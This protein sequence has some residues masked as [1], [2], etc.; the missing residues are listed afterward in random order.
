MDI[1][2]NKKSIYFFQKKL[3]QGIVENYYDSYYAGNASAAQIDSNGQTSV[4]LAVLNRLLENFAPTLN[5][6]VSTFETQMANNPMTSANEI[7]SQI[8]DTFPRQANSY[9]QIMETLCQVASVDPNSVIKYICTMFDEIMTTGITAGFTNLRGM[10]TLLKQENVYHKQL[11]VNLMHFFV[12]DLACV[13]ISKHGLTESCEQLIDCGF[14]LCNKNTPLPWLHN[15]IIQQW[16]VLFS[17][18]SRVYASRII[19]L[20]KKQIKI[21]QTREYTFQMISY[22]QL[23]LS[24]AE[25]QEFLTF[26]VS[27]IKKFYKDRNLTVRTLISISKLVSTMPKTPHLIELF[28]VIWNLRQDSK[29]KDGTFDLLASLFIRLD[30]QEKK[31]ESFFKKRVYAHTH[32][33]EKV[34]RSLR[35]FQRLMYGPQVDL[36]WLMWNWGIEAPTPQICFIKWNSQ[37]NVQQRESNSFSNLFMIHFFA[38]S[39]FSTAPEAFSHTLVHLASIDFDYFMGEIFPKFLALGFNDPRF[40]VL[41]M[42]V[43]LINSPFF[44]ENALSRVSQEKIAIMNSSMVPKITEALKVVKPD[45]C[46]D[47]VPFPTLDIEMKTRMEE[48]DAK[49]EEKLHAWKIFN[50]GASRANYNF[51]DENANPYTTPVQLVKTLRFILTPNDF[52]TSK[53]INMCVRLSAHKDRGIALAAL[54]I[55]NNI[56]ILP[57]LQLKFVQQL[58]ATSM[59][60]TT[61]ET[62]FL[63][64]SLLLTVLNSGGNNFKMNVYHDI[65]L[66]GYIGFVSIHPS[67]R[68]LA[69]KL[70]IAVNECLKGRGSIAFIRQNIPMMESVV[71]QRIIA[72]QFTDSP[73]VAPPSPGVIN[74]ESA[75]L[76]HIYDV[77]LSFISEI[78]NIL[79]ATNYTPILERFH[80]N[81]QPSKFLQ[82]NGETNSSSVSIG[83]L[84]LYTSTH[85]DVKTILSSPAPYMCVQYEPY[86]QVTDRREEAC[87]H[88]KDMLNSN[89]W[90]D[91]VAFS[92]MNSI[93]ISL[94]P[95]VLRLLSGVKVEQI[96]DAIHTIAIIFRSP[97]LASSYLNELLPQLF[98][99]LAIIQS[100]FIALKVNSPRAMEWDK[101]SED[102]VAKHKSIIIDYCIILTIALT[103]PSNQ[104]PDSVW[105]LPSREIVFRFLTNWSTTTSEQLTGVREYAASAL[106][107]M[108]KVGQ[109]FTDNVIIDQ[110]VIKLLA[111]IDKEGGNTLS[112]LLYFHTEILLE[113][114]ID[115]CFRHPYSVVDFFIDS[116]FMALDAKLLDFIYKL[117]GKLLFL[118]LVLWERE[119][120][121]AK[122]FIN[123]LASIISQ[124]RSKETQER[125]RRDM[126]TADFIHTLPKNF[127]YAAESIFAYAFHVFC[128]E[129]LKTPMSIIVDSIKQWLP[130]L[131]LLPKQTTCVPDTPTD[132]HQFTPYKF[133]VAL[134]ETTEKVGPDNF[135]TIAPLWSII[136]NLP[137]HGELIPLFISSWSVMKTKE[138]MFNFL[139]SS[140]PSS[141]VRRLVPRCSFAYYFHVTECLK[142]Q[143]DN[144]LW[145]IPLLVSALQK[146]PDDIVE[147]LPKMIHFAF[148]I[149]DI[150]RSLLDAI[151]RHFGVPMFDGALTTP[152]IVS[153]VMVLISKI[154]DQEALSQWGE[155]ALRFLFG[156]RSLNV[157]YMSLIIY[158]QLMTPNG[159]N[160]VN[161]IARTSYFHLS[162]FNESEGDE[163]LL[164]QF[165][166]ETIVY[167]TANF[168]GHEEFVYKYL[169]SF[170]DCVTFVE[171]CLPLAKRL[172]VLC[173]S[174]QLT[175][176]LAWNSIVCIIRPL[177]YDLETDD[178]T[179]KIFDYLIK[180]SNAQEL[181]MIVAPV[182]ENRP[183]LFPSMT[184][185][186]QRLLEVCNET[187]MCNVL[188]HYSILIN[189]SSFKVI[190]SIF[191]I[192]TYIVTKYTN[193]NNRTPLTKLYAVALN[194]LGNCPEAI[195]FIVTVAKNMPS[196]ASK[197]AYEFYN[198]ARP[199]EDVTRSVQ[200]VLD[201]EQPNVSITDCQNISQVATLLWGPPPKIRPFASQM[202]MIDGMMRVSG[203]KMR[204]RQSTIRRIS[205]AVSLLNAT[206]EKGALL[207]VG[208]GEIQA[209][210]LKQP[211]EMIIDP[212]LFDPS[213]PRLSLVMLPEEFIMSYDF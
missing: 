116:I 111:N 11:F 155:E 55:C 84:I 3:M 177:L 141:V 158:N 127:L 193:E 9:Q 106:K 70:L 76:C 142:S 93:N 128:L 160:I 83:A 14:K 134:M 87:G 179:Q 164:T 60:P 81:L 105:S 185:T 135:T 114:Y 16:S 20:F 126:Q 89:S 35:L 25:H 75:I 125:I 131:R 42:T 182:K 210:V 13:V 187:T 154:N 208:P 45:D 132:F 101:K 44:L 176:G 170:F 10:S 59:K 17:L 180:S 133:L 26:I 73:V 174:N 212:R 39:D 213:P 103:K 4:F 63:C 204:K 200:R 159:P 178:T 194:N 49:V 8:F 85:F 119:H 66:V 71:K 30:K 48:A 67:T 78:T 156:S 99:F 2:L 98:A 34:P 146:S 130:K 124:K 201:K 199:L 151:T 5:Q 203:K 22:I 95:S 152:M 69:Y 47:S 82:I 209:Q 196:I 102:L 175:S 29:L 118:G 117:S 162:N 62:L 97:S 166:G 120:P 192:A 92:T 32:Q 12:C 169:S 148:I 24:F 41:L 27:L 161:H 7:I 79:I 19:K 110:N 65:E 68:F 149:S 205:Y 80:D 189:S 36:K 51:A 1:N 206:M 100:H 88:L 53:M 165:I 61:D 90:L 157:A 21:H 54:Y 144:E 139:I 198:W 108:V 202:E 77:W 115:C 46:V 104:I 15:S 150:D 56:L 37:P 153:T 109:V 211:T 52:A 168:Q 94:Y 167:Y 173:L 138:K 195:N 40:T 145:V 122:Q 96:P 190:N 18:I 107:A 74:L 207:E 188:P 72:Q 23:N 137:D 33:P 31:M 6:A 57:A 163:K 43:Q 181:L 143:I 64:L 86:N 121:R 147:C 112:F 129:G 183:D 197:S 191:R 38:K 113:L 50:L 186:T 140:D 58:L 123:V 172:F 171:S 136:L 28:E 91:Q 184:E